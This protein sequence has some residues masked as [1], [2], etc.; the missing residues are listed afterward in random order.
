M[1]QE[2]LSPEGWGMRAGVGKEWVGGTCVLSLG[3][4]PFRALCLSTLESE[5][6]VELGL[7]LSHGRE[8]SLPSVLH[9]MKVPMAVRDEERESSL[10]PLISG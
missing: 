6:V 5:L 7:S 1:F 10:E 8:R 9:L 3:K 4:A 2:V